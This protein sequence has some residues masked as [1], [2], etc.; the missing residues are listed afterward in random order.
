MR[1]SDFADAAIS[2]NNALISIRTKQ[3]QQLL[4]CLYWTQYSVNR[5]NDVA[6]FVMR[7]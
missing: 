1:W 3:R 5:I 6:F 4:I 2:L 7:D